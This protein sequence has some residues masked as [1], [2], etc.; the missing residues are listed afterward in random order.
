VLNNDVIAND[1]LGRLW[2]EVDLAETK[3]PRFKH[4]TFRIRSRGSNQCNGFSGSCLLF[5]SRVSP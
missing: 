5:E 1:K 4:G 2:I 3:I